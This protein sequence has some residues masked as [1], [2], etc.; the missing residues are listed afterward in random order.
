[1]AIHPRHFDFAGVGMACILRVSTDTPNGE[2]AANVHLR[3]VKDDRGRKRVFVMFYGPDRLRGR[4]VR[5]IL[6]DEPECLRLVDSRG[7][8]VEFTPITVA[9]W[10]EHGRASC[11]SDFDPGGDTETDLLKLKNYVAHGGVRC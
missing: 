8:Q 5:K 10:R 1:M 7:A 6:R 2:V 3:V 9:W 4:E 11:C